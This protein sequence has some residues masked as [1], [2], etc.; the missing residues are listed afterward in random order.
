MILVG[1]RTIDFTDTGQGPA[2][3]FVPGSYSTGAAWKQ[4]QKALPSGFRCLT[5]S[6]CGYG[7]TPESRTPDDFGI[8][9]HVSVI[10]AL[11]S[12]IAAPVHLVGHSFGGTV[13][14]AAAL[15]GRVH[16][17][18]LSTFEANPIGMLR[19]YQGGE[20]YRETLDMSLAFAAAVESG[21]ADAPARIIDFWGNAGA[22]AAMPDA[23]KAYCRSVAAVNVLDWKSAFDFPVSPSDC[24]TLQVPVLLVRGELANPAMV[25][26]T[27]RLQA[28]LPR[29]ETHAVEGAGHFL[30]S[31]HAAQCAALLGRFLQ[32]QQA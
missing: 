23:F 9:H 30:I 1:G 11:A 25:D 7:E 22:F 8:H 26:I 15:S 12:Y 21:E 4:I 6:L 18:S 3:L 32:R 16:V 28:S 5:T 20:R 10:E 27:E 13:A 14:L 2:V 17:A 29:A 19:E 31:T 24:A